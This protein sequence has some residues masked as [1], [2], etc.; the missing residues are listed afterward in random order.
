MVLTASTPAIICLNSARWHMS[1]GNVLLTTLVIL[2]TTLALAP[3]AMA[4]YQLD[5]IRQ[6][7]AGSGESPPTFGPVIYLEIALLLV[8]SLY[9]GLAGAP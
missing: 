8:Q 1:W 4:M 7:R 9:V 5:L 6:Y 3:T 2:S